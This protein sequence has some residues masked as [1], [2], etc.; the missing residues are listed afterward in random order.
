[1][2]E[3]VLDWG[4]NISFGYL[5]CGCI[6][7][8]FDGFQLF[9]CKLIHGRDG[10]SVGTVALFCIWFIGISQPLL[11]ALLHCVFN[12]LYYG[13]YPLD[14]YDDLVVNLFF[15]LGSWKFVCHYR[16]GQTSSSFLFI[17]YSQ[18]YSN[19]NW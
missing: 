19:V 4:N 15:L 7:Y 6:K 2:I 12:L 13:Y 5:T 3:R 10:I 17:I 9:L 18:L 11:D 8:P 16:R 1:M 14:Q